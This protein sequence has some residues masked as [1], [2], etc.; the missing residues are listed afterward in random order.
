MSGWT[1][2]PVKAWSP[3]ELCRAKPTQQPMVALHCRFMVGMGMYQ[4]QTTPPASPHRGHVRVELPFRPHTSLS[5]KED[6]VRVFMSA[7][8]QIDLGV[9][10][11]ILTTTYNL[12]QLLYTLKVLMLIK[13]CC[14]VPGT[15][16][17][18]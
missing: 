11:R 14:P 9:S 16:S 3:L 17:D 6:P 1:G 15:Y 13:Y 10:V 7:H 4:V 12:D 8:G 5:S 18:N 2:L